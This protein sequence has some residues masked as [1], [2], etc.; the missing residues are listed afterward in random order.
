MLFVTPRVSPRESRPAVS[1]ADWSYRAG[2]ADPSRRSVVRPAAWPRPQKPASLSRAVSP[3]RRL[4][5]LRRCAAAAAAAEPAQ[6][7]GR[8]R[9][10]LLGNAP[11]FR[12]PPAPVPCALAR[13]SSSVRAYAPPPSPPLIQ[14]VSF[15]IKNSSFLMQN[16]SF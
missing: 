11:M 3:W 9:R 6:R 7:P 10:A 1:T 15:S 4:V 16:S 2:V 12:P 14:N 8:G 5:P 13:I